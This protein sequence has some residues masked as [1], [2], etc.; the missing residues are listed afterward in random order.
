ML[1]YTA[2]RVSERVG[3][4]VEGVDIPQCTIFIN[5]GKRSTDRH[6]L[7]P[8]SFRFVLR[9]H[10]KAN[11]KN[12]YLFASRRCMPFTPRRALQIVRDTATW[13]ASLSTSIPTSSGTRC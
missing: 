4:R 1:F 8:R 5:H 7:F 6:I 13:R 12:R 3:I 9:S 10:L 2:V 11:P